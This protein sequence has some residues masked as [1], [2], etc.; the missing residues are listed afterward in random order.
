VVSI[1]ARRLQWA[2]MPLVFN[3]DGECRLNTKYFTHT[4]L[5][6]CPDETC[7]CRSMPEFKQSQ[8]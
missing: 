5:L 8:K 2:E 7:A 1:A 6:Q 3:E 4:A